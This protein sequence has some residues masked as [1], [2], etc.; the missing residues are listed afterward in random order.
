MQWVETNDSR[1]ATIHR[2]GKKAESSVTRTYKVFGSSSDT[3]VH[4]AAN[5]KFSAERF[6]QIG[7]YTLM[8]ESYSVSYLGDQAWEVT[9]TYTKTGADDDNPMRRTRSFDTGGGTAHIT[10]A[11]EVDPTIAPFGELR[12]PAQG[13]IGSVPPSQYGAIAVDGET[14]HGVDIVIPALQWTETYDVPSAY[15][16]ATYVKRVAQLTG[17]VNNAAFRTFAA[18]EVLF[19]GATGSQ[20]WDSEK[21]D[22]PWQLSYKFAASPNAG[23]NQ[24]LPA[25]TIGDITGIEKKG[26][27]Y[28]WVRYADD[29][30][31][32]SKIKKPKFVYVDS[33]YRRSN[34]ALLGIGV[35]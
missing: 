1:S 21:G 3:E 20:E 31:S 13:A 11:V 14:V 8:V 16:T 18:G 4:A 32:S 5:A 29:V 9:V 34:F 24:T 15:V 12:F 10:Q 35:T 33:V 28:L 27:D 23:D 2:K 6:Y 7:E 19:V 30:S 22:G 25:L 17:T 26:H